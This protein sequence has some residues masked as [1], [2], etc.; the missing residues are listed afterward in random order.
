VL[1]G[2]FPVQRAQLRRHDPQALDF[3]PTDHLADQGTAYAVGLDEDKASFGIG[4]ERGAYPPP[5]AGLA[6]GEP[7]SSA[8]IRRR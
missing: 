5:L 8:R 3:D 1:R 7:S 2:G 6:G 4:H